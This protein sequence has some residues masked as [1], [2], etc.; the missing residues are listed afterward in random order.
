MNRD[1]G[2]LRF[3]QRSGDQIKVTTRSQPQ[4]QH[5]HYRP[6]R[7]PAQYSAE[8][9]ALRSQGY[10]WEDEWY[11]RGRDEGYG[12]GATEV[13]RRHV[14]Q[15]ASQRRAAKSAGGYRAA[16]KR[17]PE[18]VGRKQPNTYYEAHETAYP[19]PNPVRI[20]PERYP[21][22]EFLTET[23]ESRRSPKK[24][25]PVKS[26]A[27]SQDEIRPVSP[28]PDV[29]FRRTRVSF[30]T[31]VDFGEAASST[32]DKPTLSHAE[33]TWGADGDT[34]DDSSDGLF[35]APLGLGSTARPG[36]SSTLASARDPLWWSE[37]LERPQRETFAEP[38]VT[39][40]PPKNERA[41]GA[42]EPAS[43]RRGAREALSSDHHPASDPDI[44]DV[45]YH[46]MRS[47]GHAPVPDIHV[48]NDMDE[49]SYEPASHLRTASKTPSLD[50]YPA[51]G[52]RIPSVSYDF[53]LSTR[54]RDP[55]NDNATSVP[56]PDVSGEPVEVTHPGLS[57]TQ[58]EPGYETTFNVI[59][60]CYPEDGASG[61][62][63]VAEMTVEQESR[64]IKGFPGLF[65]WM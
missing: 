10:D 65:R 43:Y 40:S 55:W 37:Y 34:S 57:P 13:H 49:Y 38:A 6:Y 59:H 23:S 9:R 61:E 64:P 30:G 7:T 12:G 47:Q 29:A 62:Q 41:E 33:A 58:P 11:E 22:Q 54:I 17:S 35:A 15:P 2:P 19:R 53:S 27:S 45:R 26:K 31:Q 28:G 63:P 60:S 4:W 18:R 42:H 52:S 56:S 20:I 51:F 3:V 5:Q 48:Y 32:D 8:P 46:R 16:N 25:E 39:A 50:K 36:R 1:P 24:E 14:P 44:S 21:A